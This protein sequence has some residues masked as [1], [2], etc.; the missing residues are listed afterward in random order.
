MHKEHVILKK[1]NE[2]LDDIYTASF[3]A[4]SRYPQMQAPILIALGEGLLKQKVDGNIC[5]GDYQRYSPDDG[6]LETFST[7]VEKLHETFGSKGHEILNL[8]SIL[9]MKSM[10]RQSKIELDALL[11]VLFGT[12]DWDDSNRIETVFR[13]FKSGNDVLKSKEWQKE[14]VRY[15]DSFRLIL[16]K[17]PR[18]IS[19]AEMNTLRDIWKSFSTEL[20]ESVLSAIDHEFHRSE[21]VKIHPDNFDLFKSELSKYFL[22][23]VHD[24]TKDIQYPD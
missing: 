9:K 2:I 12:K 13:L 10:Y 6:F 7:R 16:E 22:V 11:F 8:V 20:R 5:L 4:N 23:E 24:R 17:G 14:S 18:G 15:K 1:P 21:D 19:G 3:V